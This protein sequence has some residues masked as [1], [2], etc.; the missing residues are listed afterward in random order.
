MEHVF[1]YWKKKK[2]FN[3]TCLK[4][5]FSYTPFYFKIKIGYLKMLLNDY[6]KT[7]NF[8]K[9]GSYFTFGVM[10]LDYS[11]QSPREWENFESY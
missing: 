9:K 6:I 11:N 2:C 7:I 5:L 4:Y 1:N 10:N 8:Q 3:Y